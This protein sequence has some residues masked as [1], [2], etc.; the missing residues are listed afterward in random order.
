MPNPHPFN[1]TWSSYALN[2]Q[3]IPVLDGELTL[4]ID[5][6]GHFQNGYHRPA[7]SGGLGQPIQLDLHFLST[8]E[9]EIT[10]RNGLLCDYH[11]FVVDDP[12][13]QHRKV[14][15]GEYTLPGTRRGFIGSEGRDPANVVTDQINGTWVA[16]QP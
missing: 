16:T 1:G 15:I 7:Q 8:T 3:D 2:D 5:P 10:E 6:T 14:I 11:G 12:L 13:H 9:I 4:N